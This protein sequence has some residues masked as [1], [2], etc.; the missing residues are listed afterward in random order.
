M[1]AGAVAPEGAGSSMQALIFTAQSGVALF[2]GTQLAGIVMDKFKVGDQFQWQKVWMVP[3]VIMLVC[4]I[5][6]VLFYK[7]TV[8]LI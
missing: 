4:V 3:A 1:Y 7:G 8:P 5:A 2:G 6:L